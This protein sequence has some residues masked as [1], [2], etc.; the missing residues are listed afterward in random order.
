MPINIFVVFYVNYQNQYREK[1]KNVKEKS[2][3]R[4]EYFA[5]K[6]ATGQKEKKKNQ[7]I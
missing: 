3:Q 7:R 4:I 1:E 2:K 5:R 6:K